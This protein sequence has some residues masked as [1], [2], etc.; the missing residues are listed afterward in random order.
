MIILNKNSFTENEIKKRSSI[1][2][3]VVQSNDG[4]PPF[5]ARPVY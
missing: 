1:V 5:E 3:T 2:G 4:C